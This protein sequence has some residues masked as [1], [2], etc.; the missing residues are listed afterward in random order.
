M[1]I[2][3]RDNPQE[4]IGKGHP[5]KALRIMHLIPCFH[6]ALVRGNQIFLNHGPHIKGS[7]RLDGDGLASEDGDEKAAEKG[8]SL[9]H[10]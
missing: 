3:D 2:R 8:L 9:I 6:V 7:S 5:S 1:C 10:I 4:G